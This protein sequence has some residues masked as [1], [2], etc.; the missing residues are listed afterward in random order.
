MNLKLLSGRVRNSKRRGR[1][2]MSDENRE[3]ESQ[4]LRRNESRIH[5]WMPVYRALASIEKR[6]LKEKRPRYIRTNERENILVVVNLMG[7][8]PN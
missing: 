5:P 4:P 2:K 6:K 3:D 7:H 1:W 8:L